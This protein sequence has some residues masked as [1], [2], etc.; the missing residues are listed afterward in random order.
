MYLSDLPRPKKREG[1]VLE[2][3]V[4]LARTVRER[5]LDPFD[6]NV[7]DLFDR[8]R[9]LMRKAK[10]F[11]AL[12]MDLLAVLGLSDVVAMQ[13]KWI[14]HRSSLLYI[15][16]VLTLMRID[17]LDPVALAEILVLSMHPVTE[18]EQ[19]TG[20]RLREATEY[21]LSLPDR[22]QRISGLGAD[23]AETG[24]LTREDLDRVGLMRGRTFE[25]WISLIWGELLE[26]AGEEGMS[27]WD[28]VRAETYEDTV[29]RA[30]IVSHLCSLGYS[31]IKVSPLEEEVL[32]KPF[33]EKIP[34][35]DAETES[36][37]IA[38]TREGLERVY[39]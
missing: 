8:I 11:E 25:E 15:D 1:E 31:T 17:S 16:P 39:E 3:V 7:I 37:S 5:S 18:K 22:D 19:L 26:R 6:V 36:V 28:F 21:W 29:L 9:P 30:Y 12:R 38:L 13:E 2:R 10:D 33:P 4:D 35:K 27:Y 23:F 24:S 20:P 14:E 32:L 34:M